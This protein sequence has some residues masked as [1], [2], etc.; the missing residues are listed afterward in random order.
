MARAGVGLRAG[1]SA[2]MAFAPPPKPTR[3]PKPRKVRD[4]G[5]EYDHWQLALTE[6]REA[7]GLGQ[8]HREQ[9]GGR[10]CV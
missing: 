4:D 10:R 3:A 6:W 5:S 8:R 2:A 7:A 1:I 9:N